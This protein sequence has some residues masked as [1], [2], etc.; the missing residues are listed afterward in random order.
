MCSYYSVLYM[1]SGG[2]SSILSGTAMHPLFVRAAT[3][4]SVWAWAWGG[5]MHVGVH[6]RIH[7][8][9]RLAIRIYYWKTGTPS[10]NESVSHQ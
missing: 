3:T 4:C 2:N 7:A 1:Q 9:L 8:Y 10:V 5:A 6:W